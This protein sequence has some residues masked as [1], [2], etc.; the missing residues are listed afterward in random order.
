MISLC[1]RERE[2]ERERGRHC[3]VASACWASQQPNITSVMPRQ[4]IAPA[5][6]PLAPGPWP[7]AP[8]PWPLAPD[9][10]PGAMWQIH[11]QTLPCS[12]QSNSLLLGMERDQYMPL[13]LS[14]CVSFC[15]SFLPPCQ[16]ISRH[17]CVL[18]K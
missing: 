4:W 6:R 8:G 1:S 2:R 12:G 14:F 15:L 11:R 16:C 10:R 3:N 17:V 7:L 5:P 18:N 9:I 13:F